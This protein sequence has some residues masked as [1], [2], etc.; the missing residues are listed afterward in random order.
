M[1]EE[2][3]SPEA[4]DELPQN[5]PSA[6][7]AKKAKKKTVRESSQPRKAEPAR[8]EEA[9]A[10]DARPPI[11]RNVR[12]TKKAAKKVGSQED[13][14]AEASHGDVNVKA[15]GAKAN[16]ASPST[17]DPN[18]RD[19]NSNAGEHQDGGGASKQARRGRG[20]G[21]GRQEQAPQEDP[22]VKLDA[23]KVAK[24]AWKIFL[25]EVGEEGLALIADKDARELARRSLRV[26]EIYSREEAAVYPKNGGK[27]S[28]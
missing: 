21:R 13:H 23:K 22:K 7:P 28:T 3:P 25:G 18:A 12:G 2:S 1:P 17:S 14:N 6:K 4:Q 11:K 16:E 24:R 9:E 27:K 20:R 19:S 8:A 10:T 15:S 26:A 5:P